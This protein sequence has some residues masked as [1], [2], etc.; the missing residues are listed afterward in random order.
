MYAKFRI[1]KRSKEILENIGLLDLAKNIYNLRHGFRHLICIYMSKKRSIG[2]CDKRFLELKKYKNKH[3][4]NRCFIVC[5]GPSLTLDDVNMLKNEYTFGVNSVIKLFNQTDWRPTYYFVEDPEVYVKLEKEIK[6]WDIKRRFTSDLLIS[7]LNI[8]FPFIT[9]PL[10]LLNHAN[11]KKSHKLMF[12]NDAYSIVYHGD[13]VTFSVLQIA[14]YMGFKEIYLIGCDCNYSGN[15]YHFVDYGLP[16]E[17]SPE[18][19]MIAAYKVAKEYA[20]NH[21]IKIYNA[22]RGGKLEVF[23]RVDFDSL[24]QK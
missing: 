22:T 15:S 23:E 10:D 17:R 7:E 1:K 11:L 19:D 2:Y 14:V 4:N 6:K 9:Y 12:S 13:T 5:T 8:S 18:G 3:F 20:E 21:D 16:V 24:F